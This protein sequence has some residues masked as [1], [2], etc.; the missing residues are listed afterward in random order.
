MADLSVTI[1]VQD[2]NNGETVGIAALQ[3]T[4]V[5]A[6]KRFT[7]GRLIMTTAPGTAI[8]VPVGTV[9]II[10]LQNTD[11]VNSIFITPSSGG[12]ITDVLLPGEALC[13]RVSTGSQVPFAYATAGTPM[14]RYRCFEA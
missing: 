5:G 12:T 3:V 1:S 4:Q 13:K 6:N 8:P 2:L 11:A 10:F 9:G 14:L 7:E